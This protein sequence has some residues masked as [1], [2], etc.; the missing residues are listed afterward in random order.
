MFAGDFI[1]SIAVFLIVITI[2][3]TMFGHMTDQV[4]AE[5]SR[6][7]T[8]MAALFASDVLLKTSGFPD[9]WNATNAVSLGLR[10]SDGR[11][12]ITKIKNFVSMNYNKSRQLLGFQDIDFNV[13]FFDTNNN[14]MLSGVVRG[15]AAYFYV[16]NNGIGSIIKN[17]GLVWDLYYGGSGVPDSGDARNVYSGSKAAMFSKMIN[18]SDIYRTI[19]MEEPQLLQSD[20]NISKLRDFV[21]SGGILIFEGGADLIGSGFSMHGSSGAGQNGVVQNKENFIEAEKD[22]NITFSNPTWYFYWSVGD[23]PLTILASDK[24]QPTSALIGKWKYNLGYIYYVTD[25]N[26]A[27][28]SGSLSSSINIVGQRLESGTSLVQAASLSVTN[29]IVVLSEGPAKIRFLVWK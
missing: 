2:L 16:Q 17:S 18:N 9:E 14:I 15:P 23:S 22:T 29:R 4:S 8:D 24:D 12:N 25:I 7:D 21:S 6:A 27:I 28:N 3:L 5:Q 10:N 13:T 26:G 11:L 19:I 1:I 20:I